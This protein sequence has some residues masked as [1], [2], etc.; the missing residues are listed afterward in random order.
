M[1]QGRYLDARNRNFILKSQLLRKPA[2]D[3]TQTRLSE[4]SGDKED[5]GVFSLQ[6]FNF[7]WLARALP[8][9]PEASTVCGQ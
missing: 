1:Q 8:A 6:R 5:F 2:H 4:P 9:D 7:R 3:R